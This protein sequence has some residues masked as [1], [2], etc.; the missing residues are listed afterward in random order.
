MTETEILSIIE[1]Q[2]AYFK[3][4]KTL[5]IKYRLKF[6]KLLHSAIK[7]NLDIIHEGLKKDLGK[8]A[9]ESYMCE[10]GFALSELSY[11]IKNLKKFASP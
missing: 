1:S 11:M 3:S 9:S 7:N 2:R 4:G 6:L 8:S 5:D 10:T